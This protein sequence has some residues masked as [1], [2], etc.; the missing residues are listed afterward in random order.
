M[1]TTIDTMAWEVTVAPDRGYFERS[2]RKG[3][4][5]PAYARVRT[6]A[7]ELPEVRIGRADSS[8]GLD[9]EI[10]LS[11]PYEDLGISR[12]HTFL[13]RQPDGSYALVDPGSMN[14]TTVNRDPKPIAER[15]P[16]P[17]SDG[18]QVHLGWWTT[19]TINARPPSFD[20]AHQYTTAPVTSPLRARPPASGDEGPAGPA[21]LLCA[22][23]EDSSALRHR[24]PDEYQ[25]AIDEYHG[26]LREWCRA[27]KGTVVSL[28]E[29]TGVLRLP[30]PRSTVATALTVLAAFDSSRAA[31]HGMKV[32]IGIHAERGAFPTVG[33]PVTTGVVIAVCLAGHGG[34]VLVSEAAE[35]MVEAE[36][37]GGTKLRR[38][39]SFRLSDL[40]ASQRLSQ[41][42]HPGLRSEFPPP[43][44]LDH[45]PNNLPERQTKFIGR[46]AEIE[47]LRRLITDNRLVT[48]TGSGG[49]GKTSLALQVAAQDLE[50][51]PGGLWF[52][53]LS[54][55]PDGAH[56]TSAVATA[57]GIEQGGSGTY[58]AGPHDASEPTERIVDQL[59]HRTALL[60]LD[61][62]EHV[63]SDVAPLVKT[64]LRDCSAIRVVATSRESLRLPGEAV[65][66]LGPL[67]L[68]SR[69]ATPRELRDCASV[70]LFVDRA[71]LQDPDLLISDEAIEHVASIC[72]R[73][74]GIPFAIELA[75][76]RVSVLAI[77]QIAEMLDDLMTGRDTTRPDTSHQTTVRSTIQWSYDL[78]DERQQTLFRRLSV[79]AGGFTLEAARQV[80]RG[81]DLADHEILDLLT[82]LLEKSLVEA[83]THPDLNRYRLLETT[84]QYASERL[85]ER[86]EQATTVAAH[87]DWIVSIT[88]QAAVELTGPRQAQMLDVL[89]SEHENLYLGFLTALGGQTATCLRL[90]AAL[91][92]F[93][94][95]RGLIGEG[96]GWLDAALDAV[97]DASANAPADWAS[98]EYLALR[99]EAL[100]VAG[101]LAC[102]AGEYGRAE[103][104][105]MEASTI[106]G[107]IVATRWAAEALS[108]RGI[109]AGSQGLLSEATEFH[110]DALALGRESSDWWHTAF[111]L[112]NLGNMLAA[113]GS[114]AEARTAYE[115][116]LDIRRAHGDTWGLVWALFR[117]GLLTTG[118][119]RYDDAVRCL[120]EALERSHEI[121]FRQGAL[122]AV[123]GL[124]E[125]LH[126]SG[127]PERAGVR[128][129]EALATARQL[130]EPAVACLALAGLADVALKKG[131]LRQA[132]TFLSEEETIDAER[133]QAT[134]ATLNR[135]RARLA[136]AQGNDTLADDGHRSALRLFHQ[137]GDYR[138][139]VEELEE[140]ALVAARLAQPLRSAALLG[141]AE[142]ARA[143][144]GLPVPAIQRA[145]TE[146]MAD[147]RTTADDDGP[148]AAWRAGATLS[149][150]EAVSLALSSTIDPQA[151][152]SGPDPGLNP[153]EEGIGS[154][155][156]PIKDAW[157]ADLRGVLADMVEANEVEDLLERY[158]PA[159]PVAY[160]TNFPAEV[161]ASDV[162][163]IEQ[164]PL[165]PTHPVDCTL[166]RGG[167]ATDGLLDL[168]LYSQNRLAVAD[169]LP[170]LDNFG[171]RV[172]DE[173]LYELTPARAPAIWIHDFGLTS[174]A[175][176]IGPDG[177][178]P[179]SLFED[180]FTRVSDGT[181]ESDGFNH[182]V[183]AAGLAWRDV[184]VLR[185]Y[186]RYL[187]QIKN[188]FSQ[189]YMERTLAAHP[190][191]ARL[192]VGLF[193]ARLSPPE[194][195]GSS[196]ERSILDI[197][198]AIVDCIDQVSSLDEDRVLRH[199][200][201]LMQATVRTNFFQATTDGQPKDRLAFK[202]DPN[203]IP[204]L[205]LP[206]PAA[207]IFVYSP[208]VEGVHLRGGK[209]A[210]GGIRWS[211]RHDDFRTE[212]LGLMKAQTIKNVVTIPVGAK[213]GFVVKQPPSDP[214]ARPAEVVACYQTF[215]RGL[216]DLTD[217]LAG[218][219]IVVP[220]DVVRRDGDDPY[221]V[222]AADKGTATFSDTANLISAEYDFWLGDAFASGGS[223]G[224]DHKGI[225]IT[226]RGA[227]E[228]VRCHFRGL[229]I[230]ADTDL[231]T[232]IGVGDMSGDV[233][234]NG[235]LMSRQ[236]KL[237][238]AFDHRHIFLDPDP[239][240]EV[241]YRERERLFALPS[242]SWADYDPTLISAG[243]G[244]FERASS[245]IDLS[246][247]IRMLL[248]RD[249]ERMDP[250]ELVQALLRAPVDLFWN[251]GV[252]TFV[253]ASTESAADAGDRTNDA[254]RVD[255]ADLRCR[256]A[257][258]GGNLG[259]TQRARVEFARAGGLINTDAIDNSAGV[260]CSDHEVNLKIALDHA[261]DSGLTPQSRNA[262][263]AD[264]TDEVA[265]FVLRDN[266][267]QTRALSRNLE[268]G[269][270]LGAAQLLTMRYL[271]QLG[272]LDRRL[273]SLPTDAEFDVR[274]SAGEAL[275]LPE[276][277]V[278]LGHAKI[279][280]FDQLLASDIPEDRFACLELERYFP[281]RLVMAQPDAV[282][283]HPLRREIIANAVTNDLLNRMDLTFP[284]RLSDQMDVPVADLARAYLSAVE[285]LGTRPLWSQME[286]LDVGVPI[287]VQNQLLSEL[288]VHLEAMIRRLLRRNS[289]PL[290]INREISRHAEW[291]AFLAAARSTFL[292]PEDRDSFDAEVNELLET[293]IPAGLADLLAGVGLLAKAPDLVAIADRSSHRIEAVAAV[294][295]ALE[296]RAG[297]RWIRNEIASLA[298]ETQWDMLARVRLTE[299]L[300]DVHR[301]LTL[302]VL[303]GAT[304]TGEPDPRAALEAWLV[305]NAAHMH[306]VEQR[307]SEMRFAGGT[308]ATTLG[309]ALGDLRPRNEQ[310]AVPEGAQP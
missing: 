16:F 61:R 95:I 117:L 240:P 174:N 182:L 158:G 46:S 170:V 130:E 291:V 304:A 210:R 75:A 247:Q 144:S 310:P 268:L 62:C 60:V 285:L 42:E 93:W 237:V 26:L 21:W 209:V 82:D 103:G 8:R 202:F 163:A 137:V 141:A 13:L 27:Q 261:V 136:T 84:R 52:A 157:L 177:P 108:I 224:Y 250:E 277:A 135:S 125:A 116:S 7:L 142:A 218:D 146:E 69:W 244:T 252:G 87:L 90:T 274:R 266:Q 297:L 20:R 72:Q 214:E 307:I 152:S 219:Q 160:W 121:R 193:H 70:R 113:Q 66:H 151:V 15:T 235:M 308:N 242:S 283:T 102:F 128:Y 216:L 159:F 10:D 17:L 44:S 14:G 41:L 293:G 231:L 148:N 211:D 171:L 287:T 57:L 205:P 124:G 294:Y 85:E 194:V 189:T 37:D 221:L 36:L 110:S 290:D 228:S 183:L 255:A 112:T 233:F 138:G 276:L 43:Y 134:L 114:T 1:S 147:Q 201:H 11:G 300:D 187:R 212:V 245:R 79:F 131:H 83:E 185:A 78:L 63:I 74:D 208:R 104:H 172:L 196:P 97:A 269:H 64:L 265:E 256:V 203:L 119:G 23:I 81:A 207:E 28:L 19:I 173:H 262:L 164:R 234:G 273:E 295:F 140:L 213:G 32:R 184:T 107:Q 50:S 6:F 253:K 133:G 9:P 299:D 88:D 236:L 51:F 48:V 161:A 199:Y 165:Q 225:G 241:S 58:A 306:H 122:L 258:E 5:F 179:F 96:Q 29:D 230:D 30:S 59:R 40:G 204:D 168:R 260:D 22:D 4:E 181:T 178:Q 206:R 45:R 289:G 198:A 132:V 281:E 303:L 56:V 150:D 305:A 223:A 191:I 77:P 257:C 227:W 129:A 226:A 197:A 270:D 220:P 127:D 24:A 101:S 118:E 254:I 282:A 264:L 86:G 180:A 18:D 71:L 239:D 120:E 238:G 92:L 217:N 35:L 49:A 34:Q 68:P 91:R 162:T 123:L 280:L 38:L 153:I 53:D 154:R 12:L 94:L 259:W 190:A 33:R 296:D 47:Q 246:P 126:L 192:L 166:R 195:D 156:A 99:A 25:A 67:E 100:C 176:A 286:A 54:E 143:H 232:V 284:F 76:A 167:D 155:L 73:L 139:M 267:L 115:E 89:E 215:I 298:S 80:C 186:G 272:T 278:L 292:G 111:A 251:G 200:L 271:E 65:L 149:L 275:T 145:R 3:V 279:H 169:V 31:A 248:A 222:V 302:A 2:A 55:V 249:E 288:N 229:G 301:E 106:S 263:L 105:A 309:I 39:G 243:G 188:A 98:E 109:V 175:V